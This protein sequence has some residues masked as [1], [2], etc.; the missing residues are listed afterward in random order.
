MLG[1]IGYLATVVLVKNFVPEPSAAVNSLK[2]VV[3]AAFIA[4]GVVYWVL[5]RDRVQASL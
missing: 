2:Y 5:N 4:G 1:F 3:L